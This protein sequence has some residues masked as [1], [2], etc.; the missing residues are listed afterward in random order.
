MS[1]ESNQSHW[2]PMSDLMTGMMLVFM[3][4]AIIYMVRVQQV[5]TDLQD[6]K[7]KIYQA[8]D[9]EFS[10]DLKKWDA[11]ILSNLTIRFKNQ[12][13]LFKSGERIPT[14]EFKNLLKDFFP[15]YVSILE[16]NEFKSTIKEVLIEGHASP[17]FSVFDDPDVIKMEANNDIKIYMNNMTLSQDRCYS[18]LLFLFE[19]DNGKFSNFLMQ[20]VHPHDVASAYPIFLEDNKTIDKEKSRR[21]EFKIITNAEERLTEIAEKLTGK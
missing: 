21:V 11:E 1:S 4:I 19:M 18:T 13:L 10:K 3:I 9:K 14:P 2:I 20:K 16:R 17:E 8:L 5:A 12:D 7:G 15:R 6:T